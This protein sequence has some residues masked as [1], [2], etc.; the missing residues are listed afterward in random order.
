MMD[1]SS[2]ARLPDASEKTRFDVLR[3]RVAE[4]MARSSSRWKLTWVL[5]FNVF[6]VALLVARGESHWRVIVQASAVAT[7][8][9]LFAATKFFYSLSLRVGTFSVGV[10]TYFAMVSTTGGLSSPL[11]VMGALMITA[12]A[13]AFRD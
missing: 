8:A 4:E 1:A 2:A 6:V 7:L 10:L 5:P 13:V 12:A 3:R 9:P 11:L